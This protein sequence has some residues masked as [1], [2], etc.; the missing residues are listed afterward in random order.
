MRDFPS[1]ETRRFIGA[2]NTPPQQQG[3]IAEDS[4]WVKWVCYVC[5]CYCFV[6]TLFRWDIP[7]V[8]GMYF[9]SLFCV[10]ACVG[11]YCVCFLL[12]TQG[13][14]FQKQTCLRSIIRMQSYTSLIC[15]CYYLQYYQFI[16]TNYQLITYQQFDRAPP[17]RGARKKP[18]GTFAICPV[19]ENNFLWSSHVGSPLD[20]DDFLHHHQQQQQHSPHR[21]FLQLPCFP[22][23]WQFHLHLLNRTSVLSVH[24]NISSSNHVPVTLNF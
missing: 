10:S 18:S 19:L 23:Q 7:F 8:M 9:L 13:S 20:N 1:C 2:Q 6:I 11:V 15:W 14:I 22:Q 5:Y 4:K 12:E 16:I 3:P 24:R 17:D 21:S